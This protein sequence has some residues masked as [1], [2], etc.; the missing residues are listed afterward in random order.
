M[1][2]FRA[3]DSTIEVIAKYTKMV[4]GIS[5]THTKS[6]FDA[7][8]AFQETFLVYLNT[9][10]TFNEEEHRKAWLI[11][12]AI[13]CC[14]KIT[15]STWR[16]KTIPLNELSNELFQF[17]SDEENLVYSAL[18]DIPEKY[19]TILHLFYFESLSVDEISKVLKIKEGTIRMQLTRG[20]EMMRTK[21]K[22]DF[23]N[24]E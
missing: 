1:H 19:R 10:K 2:S 14:K 20:R 15:S 4:Y 3:D 8:D 17:N 9:N 18:C 16:K 6:K 7:D 11:R 21:L 12:T 23:F 5:L 22:G 13:N 24:E